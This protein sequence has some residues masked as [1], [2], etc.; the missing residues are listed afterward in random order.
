MPLSL[1]KSAVGCACVALILGA[2]LCSQAQ[3]P[4]ESKSG[5]NAPV[6]K[7]I[8]PKYRVSIEV[9]RDRAKTMHEVYSSM[10][11]VMHRHYFGRQRD[12]R[13]TVPS[14]ALE[15][16]FSDISRQTRIDARWIAVNTTAM[17][18]DNEPAS[19]FEKQ[20]AREISKGQEHLELIEDGYYRR[21]GVIQL[22]GSCLTCHTGLAIQ[23]PKTPRYAALVISIP[24]TEK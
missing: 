19:D 12:E 7:P 23:P 24:L 10:L 18:I 14:R 17:S 4:A 22:G 20:A 15:E 5:S 11:Q 1:I 6:K 3:Q 2:G 21:A 16:V 8:D 9:A 13:T